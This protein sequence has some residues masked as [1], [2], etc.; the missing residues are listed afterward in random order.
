[1]QPLARDGLTAEQVTALLQSPE[2]AVSAG[3]DL[4]NADLSVAEDISDDLLG[5]SVSRNLYASIH[6]TCSLRLSRQLAWGDALVRPFMTLTGSGM[7][8]RFNVGVYALTTPQRDVGET[9]ETVDV[10]GYDRLMLLNRQVGADYL[11]LAGTTYRQA[12]LNAFSA[13]GLLGV[14]IE[15]SAADNTLPKDRL[16]PLVGDNQADPDQTDT[17][18]TYLRVVNDLL[19]AINFRSVFADENGTFVCRSY[20]DPASRAPEFVFDADD[21]VSGIVGERRSV[22]EDVWAVPNRW[23]FRQTNRPDASP[24]PTEGDGIYTVDLSDTVSG[25]WLGRRLVWTAVIDYEAASQAKLVELG[26]RRVISDRAVTSRYEV[27]VGP[28]PPLGHAD[29][30]LYRD[31]TA[32]VDRKVQLIQADLDLL[33]ADTRMMWEAA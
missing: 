12:L 22:V 15:G 20:R 11:I 7:S 26:D 8:A 14:L 29:I 33:G 3:C 10:Q 30:Y 24:A 13:A 18:V 6:G 32:G 27:T 4:L 16:W 9:P 23:V 25:D 31:A 28:F 1:V 17:P 21:L 19:R 5:G 2:L